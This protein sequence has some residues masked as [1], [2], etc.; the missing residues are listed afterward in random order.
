MD[1]AQRDPPG[2]YFA[3]SHAYEIA[4]SNEILDMQRFNQS[5]LSCFNNSS[6]VCF[7]ELQRKLDA[8]NTIPEG[9]ER[10]QAMI[11]IGNIAYEEVYFI[12]M[13]EVV[14][15]YGLSQDLE[16]EPYYAPR[17]RG[18]TMRFTQ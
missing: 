17:L 7:P 9:P 16:W 14:M 5:R 12:N 18:N 13:F 6:R 4:T 3:S 2:P 10:T 1:C 11:E 15:V 8:A